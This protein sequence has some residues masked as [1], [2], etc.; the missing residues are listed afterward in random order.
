[1][2]APTHLLCFSHL[3]WNFLYQR[4]RHLLSRAARDLSVFYIEEPIFFRDDDPGV[5]LHRDETSGV[6]VMTP[7]LREGLA[8]DDVTAELGRIVND[9]LAQITPWRWVGWY[10]T[11]AALEFTRHLTPELRIYDNMD[12]LSAITGAP[13]GILDLERELISKSDLMF[14]G[15]RSLYDARRGGHDD[16]HAFPNS[17]D[18]AHFRLA[19]QCA[20]EPFDQNQ[21]AH[22]RIGFFGVIDERMNM[23]IVASVAALRPQ[24]Q[25]V[26]IGPTAIDPQSLPRAQN[27][28]W[29]GSKQYHELPSYLSGWDV[30]IMPFAVNEATR[31]MS[32]TKTPEFL[33]AGVPVVSTPIPDVVD[34]YGVAG[35]VEIAS[36]AQEFVAKIEALL[37]R[38]KT[39][40]LSAVDA[41][42]SEMS[43]DKTWARMM[44]HMAS[45]KAGPKAA[46]QAQLV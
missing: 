17:V 44:R 8:A 24:W 2:S 37:R 3:R 43:W 40:W 36:N 30:G 42:L 19:R 41:H 21:I 27:I 1:M 11:P 38:P 12:E 35:H 45:V 14:V 6:F 5:A 18:V 10:Y 31:F 39:P 32:P 29:L 23:D 28:H 13:Q 26:M 34:P 7:I 4:P 20:L 46:R 22:P 33:A 16:M 15:G 9:L 25:L